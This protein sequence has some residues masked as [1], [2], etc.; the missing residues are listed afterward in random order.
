MG[1]RALGALRVLAAAAAIGLSVA[2]C[3]EGPGGGDQGGGYSLVG[4]IWVATDG[5]TMEFSGSMADGGYVEFV[6]RP[7]HGAYTANWSVHGGELQIAGYSWTNHAGVYEIALS[8][9]SLSKLP[10][11]ESDAILFTR[12]R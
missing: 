7:G 10:R 8:G 11:H 4:G 1:D 5:H 6:D 3:G 9:D 2:A 12:S